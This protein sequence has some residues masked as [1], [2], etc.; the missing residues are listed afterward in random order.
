M[1]LAINALHHRLKVPQKSEM[2]RQEEELSHANHD[3]TGG[4]FER[5]L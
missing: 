4:V 5:I 2:N 1:A 3:D